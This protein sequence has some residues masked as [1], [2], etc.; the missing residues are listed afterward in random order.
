MNEAQPDPM[1]LQRD[2]ILVLLLALAAASWAALV[3]QQYDTNM[4]MTLAPMT[5]VVGMWSFRV[6]WVI[7]MV[8]MMLPTAAPMILNFHRAQAGIR[9]PYDAFAS[10]WVFVGAYMLV[11]AYVGVAAYVAVLVAQ[12]A[13]ER[14]ALPPAIAARIGG[15]ILVVAG[16]YQLT[17]LKEKCL[18]H[19]RT[20]IDFILMSSRAGTADA[21]PI[22]LFHGAYCL[23]CCWLLFV[24][25]FPLGMNVEA[26]GAV[27]L[28]IFA[29]KTLPWPK[30]TPR[31]TAVMLV[32]Y[33]AMVIA[34]P[35]LL[36]TSQKMAG[37]TAMP[38]EMQMTMPGAGN[39]PA[40]K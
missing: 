13:A 16:I 19:C 9:Q 4:G 3:W 37:G 23:G 40:M 2:G 12:I 33:G 11:W 39:A 7:M 28:I 14:A 36:S 20:S 6:F 1:A 29:E 5:S 34:S 32:L 25:L 30:L 27:T 17:P 21:L 38:T 31:I 15:A 8:A 35:Q 24:S 22:G 26:M 18:S 10:T